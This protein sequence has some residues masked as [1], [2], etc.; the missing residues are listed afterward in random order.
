M[1]LCEL[2]DDSSTNEM[3]EQLRQAAL[4][5]LTPLL[6]ANV[7][8]ITINQ[9][10]EAIRN[11]RLG[12]IITR[13]ILLDVLDPDQIEAV[14]KIEGDRIYLGGEDSETHEVD[15]QDAEKEQAH[16]SDMAQDQAK[17]TIAEPPKAPAAPKDAKPKPDQ[18]NINPSPPT[19]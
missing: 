2:F 10:L 6:A 12:V 3:T 4:D 8:F 5:Y 16:V 15:A 13:E 19:Q 17:K 1:F 18:V 9:M 7:P 14:S 11:R